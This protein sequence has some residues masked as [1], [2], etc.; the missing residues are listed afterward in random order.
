MSTG[1]NTKR[2]PRG[3]YQ[4]F[5]PCDYV[6]SIE[7]H[8][9]LQKARRQAPQRRTREA[10][11]LREDNGYEENSKKLSMRGH[12]SKK[13]NSPRKT[14]P[15]KEREAESIHA[16]F[17]FR[18]DMQQAVSTLLGQNRN[19]LRR[20][21]AALVL[22]A[23]SA[24]HRYAPLCS[25]GAVLRDQNTRATSITALLLVTYTFAASRCWLK[26]KRSFARRSSAQNT[27]CICVRR[28]NPGGRQTGRFT[29]ENG[30]VRV[31]LQGTCW[32][33]ARRGLMMWVMKQM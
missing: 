8:E 26:H 22:A 10:E 1:P 31:H 24:I 15:R 13:G 20:R 25:S 2:L 23:D 5:A 3:C 30:C 18:D 29:T 11:A 6:S 9:V 19:D 33:P 27:C 4:G 16:L 14:P 28:K 7:S 32:I 12:C 21:A 17:F